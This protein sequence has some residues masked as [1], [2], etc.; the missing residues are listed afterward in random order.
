MD[1]VFSFCLRRFV[2]EGLAHD[3]CISTDDVVIEEYDMW[4]M[5]LIYNEYVKSP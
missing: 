1:I 3:V 4:T 5:Q 2:Y